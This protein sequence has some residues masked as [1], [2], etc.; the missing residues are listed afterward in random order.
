MESNPLLA[1]CNAHH[2]TTGGIVDVC[3]EGKIFATPVL[4]PKDTTVAG[5]CVVPKDK[6]HSLCASLPDCKY[7]STT[8]NAG[9]NSAYRNSAQLGK[10]ELNDNA[11]WTSCTPIGKYHTSRRLILYVCMYV[12]VYATNR[13]LILLLMMLTEVIHSLVHCLFYANVNDDLCSSHDNNH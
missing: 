11:E 12:C 9:W 10:G 6:A 7:V 5:H 4:C 1:T 2:C 13:R 8:T 3:K